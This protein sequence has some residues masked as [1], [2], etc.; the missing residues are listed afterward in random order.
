VMLCGNSAMITDVVA[1][2]E[3]RGLRRHSRREPG[4]ISLE[5]YH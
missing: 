5:K 4:H 3:G 2:L 1:L